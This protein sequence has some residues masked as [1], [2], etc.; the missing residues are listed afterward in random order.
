MPGISKDNEIGLYEST[1][2]NPEKATK[3]YA[4]K[5]DVV[6]AWKRGELSPREKVR[7]LSNE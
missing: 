3:V 2:P 7:V 1:R 4:T 6:A 5:K